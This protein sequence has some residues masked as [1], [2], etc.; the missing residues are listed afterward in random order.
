[1]RSK[2]LTE[3]YAIANAAGPF[4]GPRIKDWID[5]HVLEIA[6]QSHITR[7]ALELGGQEYAEHYKKSMVN[8]IARETVKRA[9]LVTVRQSHNFNLPYENEHKEY[10]EDNPEALLLPTEYGLTYT[11]HLTVLTD[12]PKKESQ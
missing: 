12:K 3:L 5:G 10:E 2:A 8:N 6:Q 9:A 7:E 1:M 4:I 11:T